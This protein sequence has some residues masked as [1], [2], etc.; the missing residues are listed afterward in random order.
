VQIVHDRFHLANGVEVFDA[1]K[2]PTEKF[3][4]GKTTNQTQTCF[5]IN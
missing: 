4:I 5:K 1:K 3:L 2:N